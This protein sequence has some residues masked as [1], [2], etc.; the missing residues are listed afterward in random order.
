MA[1]FFKNISNT[2]VQESAE[3]DAL[4][5]QIAAAASEAA[6]LV[7]KTASAASAASAAVSAD[8]AS[9]FVNTNAASASA[10]EVSNQASLAAKAAALVALAAAETAE[11]NAAGSQSNSASSATAAAASATAAEASKVTSVTNAQTSIT[12]ASESAASAVNSAASAASVASTATASETARAASV[13]AKDA[14]VVAKDASVVAKNASVAAQNAAVTAQN[15]SS[16]SAQTSTTKASEASTSAGTATTKASQAAT[17]A[18][19]SEASKVTSVNSASTATT[20]A[21]E[22]STSAT[23]AAASYDLFDDRMLGAKS[24]APTVDNDGASLV[25]GTLYFDTSSQTMK[26]YG[27]SGWVPAG[28]SVNG[29]S[30]RFKFVATNNQTT[31]SGSDANS[32]TLGYD[33]GF[34]DVYLSGLRLVNGTDFTA[35]TGTNI[36]LASGAA[37]GDILEIVAY[38]TFVLANFNADKLDGQ[39]GSYYTG[40]TDSA[41]SNLVNSS[42][43]ALDTLQELATAL[44]NDVNFSTTVTNSIATKAPLASPTFTGTTTIPTA[45]INAG[46]IDGTTVGASTASTGAFTTLSAS[47]VLTTTAATLFNGGF[48]SNAASTISTA[49]NLDTLSLIST[50]ADANSGPNLRLY[51]NSASPANGDNIGQLDWEGRNDNSQ[52]VVYASLLCRVR[53]NTDGTEDGGIQLDIMKDGSLTGLWKYYSNGTTSEFSINDDSVDMDFRVE[54]NGNANMLFVDGGN[55]RVGIGTNLPSSKLTVG[56]PN[57]TNTKKPTVQITDTSVGASLALRGQ[58]PALIFDATAGGVPKILM[59]SQGIEFKS[60]T[61]DSEGSVDLKLD[62]SGN[63]GIG[64]ASAAARL[65]VSG[66]VNSTH[67][68]FSNIASRGLKIS[69]A[70]R[71]SQNDGR[72]I[73]DSQDTESIKGQLDLATGGTPRLVIDGAGQITATSSV[74]DDYGLEIKNSSSTNP[75]GLQINLANGTS[76]TTQ[77]LIV[78]QS[79]GGNKFIVWT[80]GN[81]QNINNSYTGISDLKLKE[82][83]IDASSQ[84]D[85]IKALKIRKYSLKADN[86]DAPNMLGVIAQELEEAGMGGLVDDHPDKDS[87]NNDI[88]TVTKSVSYSILYMKAVKALQEAMTR[89]ETLEARITTLEGE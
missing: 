69:T 43:A 6:A 33:A 51:R 12:K 16:A 1:G 87:E 30:A 72:V 34:L 26:V 48:A 9:S 82:N 68:I 76:N 25:Q 83:I 52:D 84:W 59:D 19:A 71:G 85:D 46:T 13:V 24:S 27:A 63:V 60:G 32:Q 37:T 50:D 5:S 64:L 54:S 55:N 40:Y 2:T 15:N 3:A 53:D 7:S 38:G 14:S 35:T 70:L 58:S 41:V 17:S 81:A 62:A 4:A 86:L 80:N 67:A 21:S 11:D 45:D 18:T 57:T 47:G 20:K 78:A 22:A 61:I 42:P 79:A 77:A 29:T 66:G 28:S 39:H 23:S 89:I 10:S 44:G 88:G 73:I 49:D 74:N 75:Y 56:A 36:V 65:Q 8:S 31:F